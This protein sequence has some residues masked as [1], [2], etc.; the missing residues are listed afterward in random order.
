MYFLYV[1]ILFVGEGFEKK[2]LLAPRVRTLP[3]FTLKSYWEEALGV[4]VWWLAFDGFVVGI[5]R[6]I[7]KMMNINIACSIVKV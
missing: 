6:G 1:S 4:P 3:F 5:H 7:L 2:M